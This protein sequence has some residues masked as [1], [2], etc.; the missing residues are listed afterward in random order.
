MSKG[1]S[2]LAPPPPAAVLDYFPPA[3]ATCQY[4]SAPVFVQR[5]R[6]RP[7]RPP[8]VLPPMRNTSLERGV[9][10]PPF[11]SAAWSLVGCA[12]CFGRYSAGIRPVLGR[13][14]S[15]WV[16]WMLRALHVTLVAS[17]CG[18]RSWEELKRTV[19]ESWIV[20]APC[21]IKRRSPRSFSSFYKILTPGVWDHE[22]GAADNTHHVRE[23]RVLR[24][25]EPAMCVPPFLCS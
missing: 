7:P 4:C 10:T 22:D 13:G 1:K 3:T 19:T 6:A 11:G 2:P 17:C 8:P 15:K 18:S 14:A 21:R 20:W 24:A 5:D 12:P 23:A 9:A 16:A 25:R